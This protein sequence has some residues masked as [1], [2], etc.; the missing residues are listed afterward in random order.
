MIIKENIKKN[1]SSEE[2]LNFLSTHSWKETCNK[3]QISIAT[4]SRLKNGQK[5]TVLNYKRKTVNRD[6]NFNFENYFE[7]VK[8]IVNNVCR[9]YELQ[10][11]IVDD[12]IQET[13]LEIVLKSNLFLQYENKAAL[14]FRI[15]KIKLKEY[16][17]KK[18]RQEILIAMP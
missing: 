7:D 14:I 1:V 5:I 17:K 13:S 15:A 4:I 9:S 3:Y 10:K 6:T 2:I 11:T 8:R 12:L 18:E 16:F